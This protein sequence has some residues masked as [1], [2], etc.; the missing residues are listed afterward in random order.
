[1]GLVSAEDRRSQARAVALQLLEKRRFEN[2]SLVD[3]AAELGIALST[4]TNV[5]SSVTDL[6]NDFDGYVEEP[7]LGHVGPDGLRVEL[8]RYVDE[9]FSVIGRDRG[10]REV[11]RYRLSRVGGGTFAAGLVR[12][13]AMFTHIRTR[14]GESYRLADR[15][16]AHAFRWMTVGSLAHWLDARHVGAAEWYESMQLSIEV[17]ALAADP[18]P[19]TGPPASTPVSGVKSDSDVGPITAV[20]D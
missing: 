16:L 15:E 19:S 14:S 3:V 17:L 8:R 9:S 13:E 4:L 20:S 2:L 12:T 18:Q 10:L 11:W 7:A 5:Y 1:M 6:L